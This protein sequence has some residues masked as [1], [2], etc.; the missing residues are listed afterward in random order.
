[1]LCYLQEHNLQKQN[2]VDKIM[3]ENAKDLYSDMSHGDCKEDGMNELEN[4]VGNTVSKL[5]T[6]RRVLNKIGLL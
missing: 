4:K 6:L 5:F 3:Q 1:M 2:E